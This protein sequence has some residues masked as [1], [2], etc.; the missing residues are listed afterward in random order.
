MVSPDLDV[1][2]VEAYIE[3]LFINLLDIINSVQE[4]VLA[5]SA[6]IICG[7][8]RIAY[9]DFLEALQKLQNHESARA[10]LTSRSNPAS[11]YDD[12]QCYRTLAHSLR[13][14][15]NPKISDILRMVRSKSS[16]NP[17]DKVYGLYGIF[18][19]LQIKDLPQV[20]Y[21][22]PVHTTFTQIT[23]TAIEVEHSLH[24]LYSTCLPRLIENLPSWV[25]DW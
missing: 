21:N 16:S 22:R 4:L 19:K 23:T 8:V 7:S 5:Q 3:A 24:V 13:D 14:S 2:H 10:Y 20:D 1:S 11:F 12:T 17:E 6:V 9:Y 25:P 15:Q 18:S